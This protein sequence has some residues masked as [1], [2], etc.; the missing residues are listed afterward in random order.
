MLQ[1]RP[2]SASGTYHNGPQGQPHQHSLGR[3]PQMPRNIYNAPI[4]GNY[5]GQTS[6][7]VAPYAFTATPGLGGGNYLSQ[8][9]LRQESR[10]YS[11]PTN[12]QSRQNLDQQGRPRQAAS[13]SVS[14]SSTPGLEVSSL[15]QQNGSKDDSVITTQTASVLGSRPM[16]A[17]NLNMSV[18]SLPTAGSAGFS[19]PSPDRYR[20]PKPRTDLSMPAPSDQQSSTRSSSNGPS[21]SGMATV[22]HLYSMPSQSN[23]SPTLQTFHNSG[24]SGYTSRQAEQRAMDD[25]QLNRRAQLDQAQR[26]RRRSVGGLDSTGPSVVRDNQAPLTYAKV[27]QS[28]PPPQQTRESSLV[29]PSSAH[30]RSGSNDSIKSAR[31]TQSRP[32]SIKRE[33]AA[34]PLSPLSSNPVTKA[35]QPQKTDQRGVTVPP[36][37]SSDAAR[38]LTSPSPLSKPTPMSPESPSSRKTFVGLVQAP[39]LEPPSTA[40]PAPPSSAAAHLAALNEKDGKKGKKSRLKRAFSFGS[41]AELRRASAENNMNNVSAERAKLRKERYQDEQEAQQAAIAEKQEASGLGESIYSGQGNF[42]TGSTDNLSISSTASSASIMIRKMGKGMKKSTRSLV[43]LFRPK[44]VVGVPPPDSD[45]LEHSVA[46]VSMVTV[47]AEREKVNVNVDP[48]DQ[49][50]GG[51]GYPKLERNSMDAAGVASDAQFATRDGSNDS[52]RPRRSIVGGE[53][54]R[55]EVLAAVKKG[56][57]KRNGTDSES[58]SPVVRPADTKTPDFNLPQIPHMSDSPLSSAPSTP[59]DDRPPQ[60]GHRRTDSVTIEGE[61][62]FMSLPKF[63]YGDSKS[64]PNTPQSMGKNN[65]SFSPRI[66]FH[67]TW[68][69]Q[70]YDRRG[71]IATCNRLTPMLAQQIKE[72]LNTFKMEMEVHEQSK[73]YT[74]FF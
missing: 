50:G 66:Q 73:V 12:P 2:S 65:V 58:S 26:Y 41:A 68:Q 37:G 5:R 32:S 38:R 21:G 11:A 43:G 46:Q 57:L 56:I 18:P 22:G 60:L 64:A 19:K 61:D 24:P 74:H 47:E 20:R 45:T 35:L 59:R 23:S 6:H 9:H 13:G 29:R 3:T 10:A 72:E 8:P 33:P 53:R 15:N 25:L 54:E 31:S 44:S 69:S 62:Y 34:V 28:A 42:F 70:E 1:A 36:R 49:A 51:T 63:T 71:E 27:L 55:A 52:T 30:G 39:A 48:H 67:D 7:S 17:L 40:E 4:V 14:S 16:S